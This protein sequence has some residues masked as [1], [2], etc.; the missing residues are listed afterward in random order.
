MK[1]Q[2]SPGKYLQPGVLFYFAAQRPVRQRSICPDKGARYSRLYVFKGA[3]ELAMLGFGY[4]WRDK[5]NSQ[6]RQMSDEGT[7]P[8]TKLPKH[9]IRTFSLLFFPSQNNV[10]LRTQIRTTT[11]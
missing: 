11:H 4:F 7:S 9:T 8:E 10:F 6:S 2:G 5:S 3:H 1:G